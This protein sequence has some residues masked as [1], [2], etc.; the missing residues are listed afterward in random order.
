[1]G[2]EELDEVLATLRNRSLEVVVMMG[3][4]AINAS[5]V[6]AIRSISSRQPYHYGVE[7]SREKRRCNIARRRLRVVYARLIRR[8]HIGLSTKDGRPLQV[9]GGNV[10]SRFGVIV[11]R[12]R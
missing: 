1:V 5:T 2:R 3:Y 12:I 7:E 4:A 10:R 9:S 6:A 11:G 8:E